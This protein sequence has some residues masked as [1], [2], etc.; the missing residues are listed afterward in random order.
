MIKHTIHIL[1][2]LL[3]II[4]IIIASNVVHAQTTLWH[5]VTNKSNLTFKAIQNNAP[6]TGSFKTFSGDI[7][8]DPDHLAKSHAH[9]T[10]DMNSITASY[11]VLEDTL[12]TSDWFDTKRFPQ[13]VFTTHDIKKISNNSYQVKGDLTIRDKTLPITLICTLNDYS[14]TNARI[15]GSTHLKRTAFGVGNG[16]W[17]KTDSIKDDIEVQFSL[18]LMRSA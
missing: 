17:A 6:V 9:V 1:N 18:I 2:R 12:K 13:S 4:A 10:V 8:Y 16:E 14:K 3:A 11:K 7:V 5:I 15:D